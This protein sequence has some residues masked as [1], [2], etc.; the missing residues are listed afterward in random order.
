MGVKYGV[1]VGGPVIQGCQVCGSGT[2]DPPLFPGQTLLTEH[3]TQLGLE[4]LPTK[5]SKKSQ[6]STGVSSQ[7]THT[8]LLPLLCPLPSF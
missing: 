7:D 8:R 1:C 5:H 3:D 4:S 6:Q 2:A